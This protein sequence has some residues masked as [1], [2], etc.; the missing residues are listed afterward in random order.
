MYTTKCTMDVGRV[1]CRPARPGYHG[2]GIGL[3][4][5]LFRNQQPAA[6]MM[7]ATVGL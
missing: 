1:G 4:P 7:V 6:K 3:L 2:S 5:P